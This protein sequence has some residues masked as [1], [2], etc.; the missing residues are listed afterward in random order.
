MPLADSFSLTTQIFARSVKSA[1]ARQQVYSDHPSLGFDAVLR[2][3]NE[4][5]GWQAPNSL[6]PA[7]FFVNVAVNASVCLFS[8]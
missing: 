8:D 7:R 5:V 3:L 2:S 6:L 1:S 4:R